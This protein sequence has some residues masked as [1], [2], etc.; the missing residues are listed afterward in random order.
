M[1]KGR[2]RDIFRDYTLIYKYLEKGS[3]EE[4]AKKAELFSGVVDSRR[5]VVELE[6]TR[7][8]HMRLI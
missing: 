8:M 3:A 5:Q 1:S 7:I 4:E 2:Y 6:K